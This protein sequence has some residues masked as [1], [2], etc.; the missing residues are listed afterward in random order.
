M[1][2]IYS[3][4]FASTKSFLFVLKE[5]FASVAPGLSD[6][7][8]DK[9][10]FYFNNIENFLTENELINIE[11]HQVK[12]K[13]MEEFRAWLHLNKDC[14][15]DHASRHIAHCQQAFNYAMIR[16]Y[17][18]H[19][20]ISV[21]KRKKDKDKEVVSLEQAEINKLLSHD[22]TTPIRILA[23]DLFLFQCFTGLSYIDLWTYEIK[24]DFLI[25]KN[26]IY[27]VTSEQG[28]GKNHEPYKAQFNEFAKA[29]HDKYE[30]KFPKITNQAYNRTLKK[31]AFSL[32][33]SKDITT[34]TGRKTY[35]T[36]RYDQ[37]LSIEG[38]AYEL[39]NTPVVVWKNYLKK[40]GKR[41]KTE[42]S[43]L[44]A[45]FMDTGDIGVII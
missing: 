26:P 6:S 43:N 16:E 1:K 33:I 17:Y 39:G 11:L 32:N 30:G 28:R 10:H 27:W 22:F 9:H 35:A 42:I 36:F 41:V 34:H 13:H 3:L 12:V 18:T 19:N 2:S 31:I 4:F 24:K 40:T 14:S 44:K 21:I 38:I 29:I 20:P 5:Y 15:K 37:G 8:L 23:T 45:P 7:T 25:G